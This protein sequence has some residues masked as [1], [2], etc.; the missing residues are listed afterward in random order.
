[1]NGYAEAALSAANPD[2][3]KL[4]YSLPSSVPCAYSVATIAEERIPVRMAAVSNRIRARQLGLL[5]RLD[6]KFGSMR[7]VWPGV[8][9][10][11]PSQAYYGVALDGVSGITVRPDR[12]TRPGATTAAVLWQRPSAPCERTSRSS[13]LSELPKNTAIF[14]PISNT[15]EEYSKPCIIGLHNITSWPLPGAPRGASWTSGSRS[16]IHARSEN[17]NRVRP[18]C[19]YFRDREDGRSAMN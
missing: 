16:P 3:G 13:Q 2:F 12:R 11:G 5:R 1:M 18:D 6:T 15:G 14:Q 4:P 7:I 8:S 9:A 17:T 10:S 19:G